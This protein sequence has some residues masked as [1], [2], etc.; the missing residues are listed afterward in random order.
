MDTE[1]RKATLSDSDQ[2]FALVKRF[3][4]SFSPKRE[5]FDTSLQHL[6]RDDS[7]LVSVSVSDGEVV[8]YCLAFDHYTFYANGR[9]TWV[10]EIMVREELRGNGIGHALMESVESWAA[11]KKSK[12]IG[13]ATRRAAPFYGAIGYE[14][15][16]V[17]FR[18][19]LK[20][21]TA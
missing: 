18:K 4:T 17:F 8:G 16:A 6:L 19:M 13:L 2:V 15:S 20:A 10:E 11:S 5:A 21:P 1:I 3:A 9:V 12:L 7:V 14:E